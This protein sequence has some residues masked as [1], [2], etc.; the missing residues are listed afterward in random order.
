MDVDMNAFDFKS[1]EG[2]IG[3]WRPHRPSAGR[4]SQAT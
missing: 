2:E 4:R 1:D 3:R